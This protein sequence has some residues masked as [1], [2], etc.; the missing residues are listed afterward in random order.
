MTIKRLEAPEEIKKGGPHTYCPGCGHGLAC[1]LIF[2][3]LEEMGQMDNQ[4]MVNDVACDAII[5]SI[6]DTDFIGGA[7]GRIVPT[8]CGVKRVRPKNLVYAYVGD[9]ATYSIGM[10][11]TIH[12]AARN[13]NITVIVINNTVY[14]MTGGQ[15]SPET[16]I[17]QKT[18]SCPGGRDAKANGNPI[19]ITN[20]YHNMDIAYLARGSLDSV[21]HIKKTKTYI[22]KA[23]EKQMNGEGF[24]FVEILSPCPTNWN[25]SPVDAMKRLKEEVSQ[26]YK[27]GEFIERGKENAC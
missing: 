3:V 14:G 9:G 22:R 1:R 8:A 6:L 19:D 7:H 13:E 25:M 2:E 11:H 24:T 4:I 16:L 21:A 15:M 26:Y 23:F 12:A 20:L 27:I 5:Y 10:Q 17:G 18:T